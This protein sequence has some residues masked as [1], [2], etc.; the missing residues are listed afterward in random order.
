MHSQLWF[1]RLALSS[2]SVNLIAVT[3]IISG[4]GH[5]L[6]VGNI[7]LC[8]EVIEIHKSKGKNQND[9]SKCKNVVRGF[10]LV[11]GHDCTTLKVALQSWLGNR[12]EK[13]SFITPF[14]PL[15]GFAL[16]VPILKDFG[17][18]WLF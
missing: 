6:K 4:D 16:K 12:E 10:S 2:L 9:K 18:N 8:R 7:L 17:G 3:K 11:L 13:D 15:I 5:K 1:F 14:I